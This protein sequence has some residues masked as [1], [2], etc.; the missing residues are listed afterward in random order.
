M[1]AIVDPFIRT[2]TSM[3]AIATLGDLE[4]ELVALLNSFCVPSLHA[5]L[6]A[7]SPPAQTPGSYEPCASAAHSGAGVPPPAHGAHAGREP[8]RGD[9]HRASA[10]ENGGGGRRAQSEVHGG[11]FL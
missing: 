1:Q 6:A 5:F 8:G 10:H 11:I 2:Y 3:R 9:R 7:A 4:F